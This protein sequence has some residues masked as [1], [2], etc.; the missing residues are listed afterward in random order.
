MKVVHIVE[1]LEGG[2]Y[3]YF[4]DL[5]DFFGNEE[6]RQK[7]ETTIIYS[8]HRNGVDQMKV[9]AEFSSSV[10]LIHIGMV[11][12]IAPFHDLKSIFKLTQALRKINPDI[13][14]LHSSKAGV[15]GR[16]SCFL[17]FRKKKLF[18]SPHGYAF[19]RTDIS[20]RSQKIYTLIE[21]S[22]QHIFGGTIVACGDTEFEIAKKIGPVKLIRNGVD[23]PNIRQY[24]LPHQNT[25][26]TIGILGRVTAARNPE[27]FNKIALRFPDFQFIWIGGGE[28][29][30]FLTAP[31]IKITG[32]ILDKQNVFSALNSIDVYLQ[33]S[34]WEGLPIAVLEAMTLEKP[35]IATNIIGNKDAVVSHKTGFLFDAIEEL[36]SYFEILKDEQKRIELGKNGFERTLKFFDTNKNFKQLLDLYYE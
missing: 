32:W 35:V 6:I 10:N 11:R 26:L 29:A 27:L 4:K 20:H 23:I 30:H 36:D 16:I 14:H 7:T 34:L 2:V 22:F 5:S 1:A 17:L 28:K 8:G 19:L 12:E 15:L 25:K 3:S 13:I 31:N 24:F 18:Y 21:K 33:T 9:N